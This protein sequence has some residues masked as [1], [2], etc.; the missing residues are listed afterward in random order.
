MV[1]T[2]AL[3]ASLNCRA[4]RAKPSHRKPGAKEF[5]TKLGSCI[6]TGF[7]DR[8]ALKLFGTS[9]GNTNQMVMIMVI[10]CG[11]LKALPP[12]RQLQLSQ[13]IHGCQ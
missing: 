12:F 6:S 9:A 1:P 8:L 7:K 3:F 11:L 5:E 10:I 13:E 4:R 2:S